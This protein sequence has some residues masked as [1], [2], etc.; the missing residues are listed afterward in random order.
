MRYISALA[1]PAKNK[2]N[3]PLKAFVLIGLDLDS[4]PLPF[5]CLNYYTFWHPQPLLPATLVQYSSG[6]CSKFHIFFLYVKELSENYKLSLPWQNRQRSSW[7]HSNHARLMRL[8]TQVMR[9]WPRLLC[10]NLSYQSPNKGEVIACNKNWKQMSIWKKGE[11]W[12]R[13][14]AHCKFPIL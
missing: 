9:A 13:V 8:K 7:F 10:H 3:Q 11:I 4:S 1:W 6:P 12:E 5:P 14:Q 2:I